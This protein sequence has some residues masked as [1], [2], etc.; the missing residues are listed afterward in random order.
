MILYPGVFW[1]FLLALRTSPR[2]LLTV[3]AVVLGCGMVVGGLILWRRCRV[4]PRW[5]GCRPSRGPHGNQ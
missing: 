3:V 1:P 4:P 2:T 5:R